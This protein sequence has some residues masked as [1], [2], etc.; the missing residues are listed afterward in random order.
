MCGLAGELRLD[1]GR[2]DVAVLDRALWAAAA[3][4]HLDGPSDE[5]A[6]SRHLLQALERMAAI[7][8]QP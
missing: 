3:D 8:A 7:L 4:G 2:A 5:A 1:G 6:S